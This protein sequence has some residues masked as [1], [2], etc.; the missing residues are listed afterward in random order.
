MFSDAGHNC[1]DKRERMDPRCSYSVVRIVG[2]PNPRD[3]AFLGD[4]VQCGRPQ[5][6]PDLSDPLR[7]PDDAATL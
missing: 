5:V 3:A 2:R 4:R 1:V 7:L 6:D